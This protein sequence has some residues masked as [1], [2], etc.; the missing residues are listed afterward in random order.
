MGAN[1]KL[2]PG[3]RL[4][5]FR[6]SLQ[7]FDLHRD[8]L[9]MHPVLRFLDANSLVWRAAVSQ[10]GISQQKKGSIALEIRRYSF[11]RACHHELDSLLR[12]R[13]FEWEQNIFDVWT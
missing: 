2:G 3:G 10:R 1:Q 5:G 4:A 11:R 13:A 8:C 12:S 6:Q 7:H 9:R